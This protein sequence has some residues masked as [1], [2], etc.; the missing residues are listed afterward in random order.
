MNNK[1]IKFKRITN[2]IKFELN[3][4]ESIKLKT[5]DNVN[6]KIKP[7]IYFFVVSDFYEGENKNLLF[8]E[9]K[10]IIYAFCKITITD[11][12]KNNHNGYYILKFSWIDKIDYCDYPIK[13]PVITILTENCYAASFESICNEDSVYH[14]KDYKLKR[15]ELMIASQLAFLTDPDE[16][17]FM[18]SKK[19][20]YRIRAINLENYELSNSEK[21]DNNSINKKYYEIFKEEQIKCAKKSME[22]NINL[23][24][25]GVEF[26]KNI[27][28]E[29]YNDYIQDRENFDLENKNYFEIHYKNFNN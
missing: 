3:I 15:M 1:V 21:V 29:I 10:F 13:P 8:D 11:N 16:I 6:N 18:G 20:N 14:P 2:E 4:N 27:F 7:K 9:N 22:H 23:K 25:N 24:I 17:N 19:N 28:P 12:N 5:F 26:M